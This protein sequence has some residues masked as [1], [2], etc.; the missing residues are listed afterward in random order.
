MKRI[1]IAATFLLLS[2]CTNAQNAVGSWSLQPKAGINLA[3]MTN[4]DEAKTRIAFVAGAE[5]EYQ[6]TPL[7][8]VSAGALYSQQGSDA[9]SQG[10]NGTIKMDYVNIPILANYYVTKGLAVKVGIQPGFLVNDKVKVSA[11]GV[12]AEVGLKDAYKAAGID[13][14][15]SSFDL[16]IP[17]GISYEFNHVVLDARY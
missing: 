13:A 4:D 17:L 3:T 12:S 8:S 11:N 1:M 16:A 14:D 6:A 5:L 10:M 7:L 2:V 9:D 15:I